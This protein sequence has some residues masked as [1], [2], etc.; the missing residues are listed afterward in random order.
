[1]I[2]R[3][4]ESSTESV[5]NWPSIIALIPLPR[6]PI[7]SVVIESV[8]IIPATTMHRAIIFCLLESSAGDIFFEADLFLTG[9]FFDEAAG[10]FFTVDVFLA[11]PADAVGFLAVFTVFT[12]LAV[13][14]MFGNLIPPFPLF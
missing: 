10:L 13:F 6:N 3:N 12:V 8:I 7:A 5:E 1:M 14:F 2:R 11:A 4:S 9:G